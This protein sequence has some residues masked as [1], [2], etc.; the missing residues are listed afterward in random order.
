M[1]EIKETTKQD[2]EAAC[3][4][5][6]ISKELPIVNHLR[7]DLALYITAIYMLSVIIEAEKDGKV[8]DIT[9]HDVDKYEPWFRA[10]EG[11]KPSSSGGGFSY[12]DYALDHDSSAVG[13]RLSSNSIEVCKTNAEKYPDLWEIFIL[14]VR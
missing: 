1:T 5:L 11:Y 6:D 12:Y 4:K 2:F 10:K 8:Y 9:N 3:E 13:A 7:P 14:N